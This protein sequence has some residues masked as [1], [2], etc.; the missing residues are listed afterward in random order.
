[1]TIESPADGDSGA[2]GEG[3]DVAVVPSL[4]NGLPPLRFLYDSE[5]LLDTIQ[6]IE[7]GKR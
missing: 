3:G 4:L 6:H 7:D 2:S 1:M 5:D